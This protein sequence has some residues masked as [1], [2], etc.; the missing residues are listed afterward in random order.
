MVATNST[1]RRPPTDR[2]MIQL[3][4]ATAFNIC[5]GLFKMANR[6]VVELPETQLRDVRYA[7]ETLVSKVDRL[8]ES[9]EY[10]L[11]LNF[12]GLAVD[13]GESSESH[14]DINSLV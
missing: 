13:P 6:L 3:P 5:D 1:T 12:D 2:D 14:P 9:G 4:I 10:D 7:L 8:L 11:S